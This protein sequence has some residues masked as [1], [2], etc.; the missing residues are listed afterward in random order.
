MKQENSV[1]FNR[2]RRIGSI[3]LDTVLIAVFDLGTA[4]FP[5]RATADME[6]PRLL[7]NT[8]TLAA[9]TRKTVEGET[10]TYCSRMNFNSSFTNLHQKTLRTD[11][12]K[13]IWRNKIR[14]NRKSHFFQPLC[15]G[16]LFAP[17]K[18]IKNKYINQAISVFGI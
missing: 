4:A 7:F 17:E 18:C 6:H 8:F 3:A 2:T 10:T 9:L 12:R 1:F 16:L 5:A 11:G 13:L 15:R 14:S